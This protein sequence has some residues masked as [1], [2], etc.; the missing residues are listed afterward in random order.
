MCIVV[1]SCVLS[2]VFRSSD[3]NHKKFANVCSWIISGDGKLVYGGTK[4]IKE[5]SED[6]VWFLKFLRMLQESGKAVRADTK[7]VDA[8]QK[9]VEGLV[10]DPDFDDPHLIALIGVTGCKLIATVDKRAEKFLQ[11][12]NLYPKGINTPAI[13]KDSAKHG[14]LLTAQNIGKCCCPKKKLNKQHQTQ[15]GLPTI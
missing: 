14:A 11:D 13:F 4:F 7:K 15:I 2:K 10:T 9:I 1:D 6:Q 5:I 12:K 3:K 8:R